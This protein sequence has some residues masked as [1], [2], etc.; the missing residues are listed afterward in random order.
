MTSVPNPN[1]PQQTDWQS[2]CGLARAI[3]NQRAPSDHAASMAVLE[4]HGFTIDDL[5]ELDQSRLTLG[6]TPGQVFTFTESGM[7]A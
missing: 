6:E 3:L 7:S 4:L 2:R 1:P 5:R